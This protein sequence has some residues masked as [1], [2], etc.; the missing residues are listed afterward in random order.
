MNSDL[1][2]ATKEVI[3]ALKPL[4]EKLGQSAQAVYA[5]SVKDAVITG[6][7]E[8]AACT[9]LGVFVLLGVFILIMATVTKDSDMVGPA[10]ALIFVCGLFLFVVGADSAHNIY[11]PEYMGIKDL[12]DQIQKSK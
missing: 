10:V 7:I 1:T 2:G 8:L 5:M 6:K 11:N 9:V 3:E 4:E 12:L